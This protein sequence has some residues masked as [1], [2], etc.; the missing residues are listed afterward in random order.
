MAQCLR[1]IIW[2]SLGFQVALGGSQFKYCTDASFC[3]RY[4]NWKDLTSRPTLE[5]QKVKLVEVDEALDYR[6]VQLTVKSSSEEVANYGMTLRLYESIAAVRVQI[7]DISLIT[8]RRRFR[9][10]DGDVVIEKSGKSKQSSLSDSIS[11]SKGEKK[12]L[13]SHSSG[14]KVEVE[15]SPMK[16]SLYNNRGTLVQVINSNNFFAFE[17]Y[18]ERS[19]TQ[20]CPVGTSMDMSCHERVDSFGLWGE[21]FNNFFDEKPYG[22][23]A[24]GVDVEIVNAKAVFGLAEHTTPFNLPVFEE[25]VLYSEN[26]EP[27]FEE[28]RFYNADVFQYKMGSK[29]AI[30]GSIPFL[31]AV[32]PEG[33]VSGLVWL[34]PS[35]TFVALS[36]RERSR[37]NVESTWV[38]ETGII[39]MFVFLGPEPK[40]V[41]A[42]YYAVTGMP[43]LPPS[44]ALGHHQSKWGYA[45]QEEVIEVNA[46]FDKFQVSMDMLWLDI[47]HTDGNRYM[48]WGKKYSDPETLTK[49]VVA[50]GRK[51]VAII[52]PHV[53]VDPGYAVYAGAL[54]ND[55]LVKDSAGSVAFTGSCWPGESSYF[56][57]SRPAFREYW[58]SLLSF[59]GYKGS[60]P[61]LWIWNDMNEPSVFDGPEMS[62]PRTIRFGNSSDIEHREL[63]NLYGQYYHR[64]TFEGLLAR[65][66]PAKRP[67]VLSRSFFVGS[68]RFGPVWTGDNA[69]QWS[70]LKASIPMIL[71]LAICGLSFVGADVGGFV[72]HP[73]KEL[74]IRWHQLG[75][76]A[77]PFYRSHAHQDSPRREPWR[78]D[79]ET[80]KIV[81][82]TID[83]RYFMLPYWY[84]LA[85]RNTLQGLPIIRPLWFDH[86]ADEATITNKL[87]TEEEI[88]VG[89]SI[90]VRGV[91]E[92]EIS[93]IDVYLPGAGNWWYNLYDMHSDPLPG[94]RTVS[95]GVTLDAIPAFVKA[96]SIVPLKVIKRGS[97]LLKRQD[98][99]S[100]VV[101]PCKD[102]KASGFV[103][104]DDEQSMAFEE[105]QDYAMIRADFAES[106]LSLTRVAGRRSLDKSFLSKVTLAGSNSLL[107]G[108]PLRIQNIGEFPQ[109][110]HVS[111]SAVLG[112]TLV[113]DIKPHPATV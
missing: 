55:L 13:I 46:E 66:F 96:G 110:G 77:Y 40:D 6:E 94:G 33:A 42:Q 5:V 86:I 10:P 111:L 16:I 28:Y 112:E 73:S 12:A 14:Y 81:R 7:D 31:T 53:K 108:S 93:S 89:D 107:S 65:E 88:M 21:S 85:A 32:H 92:S 70:H 90:L 113:A 39:D 102:G 100:L 83:L 80:L 97:T 49:A 8:S 35:E 56:D 15:Y 72:G 9:I 20:L 18:R 43:A 79:D 74:F 98:P 104:I 101:W 45:S 22:P 27:L 34:N 61:D 82:S 30:Y 3:R 95:V 23:S 48:T 36:R 50:S 71:S 29:A 75:A 25:G 60:S 47:Q 44:F 2:I 67:F 52:D 37:A 1:P 69:A 11:I 64:A 58:K 54:G 26:G 41:I 68:H 99:I 62:L 106:K 109:D 91:F 105:S 57:V 19:T 24:V 76:L 87:A 63:H 84:T 59:S 51:L 103:Y 17:R 38:S 4:R 78:F